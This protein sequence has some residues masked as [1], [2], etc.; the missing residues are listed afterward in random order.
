MTDALALWC[1]EAIELLGDKR[2]AEEWGVC[3]SPAWIFLCVGKRGSAR[4]F[5]Q[6]LLAAG[7]P[8]I[9]VI[10]LLRIAS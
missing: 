4:A 3:A 9:N 6:M 5:T 7:K 8:R 10:G 2:R 1:E